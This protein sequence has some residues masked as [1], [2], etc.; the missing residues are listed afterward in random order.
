MTMLAL[1]LPSIAVVSFNLRCATPVLP[2][3]IGRSGSS[4][5]RSLPKQAFNATPQ[6]T[7]STEIPIAFDARSLHTSRGFLPWRFAY[8]GPRC[9]PRHLHGAGIRKPSH[10]R[11]FLAMG[12]DSERNLRMT[13]YDFISDSR[14]AADRSNGLCWLRVRGWS[15]RA[16]SA[17]APGSGY[18]AV[19]GNARQDGSRIC[20]SF[21]SACSN[22]VSNAD[23]TQLCASRPRPVGCVSDLERPCRGHHLRC[24]PR[25]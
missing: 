4:P 9:A 5:P 19:R 15:S 24:P 10:E 16:G 23:K 6:Q 8:A 11:S 25:S 1:A 22:P 3:A 20:S 18:F 7:A 13:E 21:F 12:F 2:V 17:D 14:K